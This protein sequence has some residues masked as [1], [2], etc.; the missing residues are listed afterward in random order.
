MNPEVKLFNGLY[1]YNGVVLFCNTLQKPVM[2]RPGNKYQIYLEN[3]VGKLLSK[4]FIDNL[5]RNAIASGRFTDEAEP[6]KGAY[7][8]GDIKDGVLS[9]SDKP[10][11][12]DNEVVA[13]KEAERLAKKYPGTKFTV[14]RIMGVVQTSG[15]SWE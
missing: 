15:V 9:F 6:V 14:L 4:D 10:K 5:Y 8:I 11:V 7:I 2:L 13:N 3:H 12:H 1:S